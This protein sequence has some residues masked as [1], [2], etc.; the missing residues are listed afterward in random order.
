MLCKHV[1][2]CNLLKENAAGCVSGKLAVA[3]PATL[4]AANS[5]LKPLKTKKMGTISKGILGG[6]SG[7]VGNVVGGN[8]KGIDYMRS[9]SAKRNF[10][11]SQAQLEQQA[12]FGMSVRFVQ[13][14]SG[15]VEQTFRNYAVK[16]TGV[17]SC[18]AYVMKNAL[19]GVYP[20]YTITYSDVLVSRGDLPNALAP[21][22]AASPGSIATFSWS[23][24][25][26]V[27]IAKDTD[28]AILVAY[29]PAT[30]QCIYSTAGAQ[31]SSLT[32][33]LNLLT[34]SGQVVKTYI[35]FASLAGRNIASSIYTGAI[36]VL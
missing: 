7:K 24:N 10:N 12:K 31:R 1:Q 13:S 25:T 27:G 5:N 36:T 11:P 18:M 32:D 14:M 23:D 6:F 15:L 22:V 28:T 20:T 29:C 16:Q 35:A 17:N 30:N 34:F 19:A 4:T 9:K 8:W 2:N 3:R 33:S 26:G 21:T